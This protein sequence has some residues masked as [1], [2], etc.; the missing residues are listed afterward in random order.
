[1]TSPSGLAEQSRSSCAPAENWAPFLGILG[2]N[3]SWVLRGPSGDAKQ[4]GKKAESDSNSVLL[5]AFRFV[6]P[7][8]T[9]PPLHISNGHDTFVLSILGTFKEKDSEDK[10]LSWRTVPFLA[11]PKG[12]RLTGRLCQH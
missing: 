5:S 2:K 3:S 10:T 12:Q 11:A 8:A 4:V 9:F 7:P 1:M 6:V